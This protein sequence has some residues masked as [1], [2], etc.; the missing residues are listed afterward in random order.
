VLR[1]E[2]AVFQYPGE[3]FNIVDDLSFHVEKGEFV[4]IIGPSGCGKSTIFRLINQLLQLKSGEILVNG[5]NISGQKNSCG[6]MPQQDLLFPWRSVEEN[7]CLPMELKGDLTKEEMKERAAEALRNVGLENQGA[8]RP[9]ELSGGMRQ[10]A[11]FARTLLTGAELLLLDEPF[12]ALDYL[13][14]ISMR[15]W[16]L[17]QWQRER[18]TVLFIT[19]DVEEAIYLSGRVLVAEHMPITQLTS[20]PVPIDYPRGR[21]TLKLPAV[22]EL[23]EQLIE[24]LRRDVA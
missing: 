8:K 15:E 1:F 3:D 24:K 23:K 19:H 5:T 16:L 13:T 18:K 22:L 4:S 21:E 12:S 11:A 20:I 6:Y 10:R 14:R 7:L 17:Q 2:H 9:S